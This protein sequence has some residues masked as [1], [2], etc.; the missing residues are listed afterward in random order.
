MLRYLFEYLIRWF[1]RYQLLGF[2]WLLAIVVICFEGVAGLGLPALFWCREWYGNLAIGAAV[3]CFF[4]LCSFIGFLLDHPKLSL[5]ATAAGMKT[6]FRRTFWLP[7]PLVLVRGGW[8]QWSEVACGNEWVVV[9]GYGAGVLAVRFA[10]PQLERLATPLSRKPWFPRL[11][12][13]LAGVGNQSA[14]PDLW[15]HAYAFLLTAILGVVY[16]FLAAFVTRLPVN[17]AVSICIILGLIVLFYGALRFFLPRAML[18]ALFA[19]VAWVFGVNQIPRKHRFDELRAVPPL[20]LAKYAEE[21][22]GGRITRNQDLIEDASALNAWR[23]GVSACGP[24]P[25]MVIVMTSGGGIRAAVWMAAVLEQLDRVKSPC[26]LRRHIRVITGA[27]GG[28][29]GAG[30]YVAAHATGSAIDPKLI[31]QDSLDSVAKYLALRDIPGQLAPWRYRDRGFALEQA[32]RDNAPPMGVRFDE[33]R[34][35]E[36]R[37]T[38]PSLI[39]SPAS[40]DDGRRVLV[41]NLQLKGLT[42]HRDFSASAVQFYELYPGAAITVSTAARMS[43]SFPWVSPASELPT[44]ELRR[45]GDAGY[46]DNFGGFVASAWIEKN[47]TWLATNTSGI[48][49]VQIRDSTFGADL[50]NVA[51]VPRD[52]DD[53]PRSTRVSRGFSEVIAPIQGVA[54]TRGAAMNFRSDFDLATLANQFPDGFLTSMDVEL[55]NGIAPLTWNLTERAAKDIIAAAPAATE[56]VINW[57]SRFSTAPTTAAPVQ[58]CPPV[59]SM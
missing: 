28:M 11:V 39:Y 56:D 25:K 16:A 26:E 15:M 50:R 9:A 52:E 4:A 10:A 12:T 6:Y 7:T 31:A 54:A 44:R 2:T 59:P 13:W 29:V 23:A 35:L 46:F 48:L 53:K 32:W 45:I 51:S 41:S 3:A 1:S 20:S 17:A 14:P 27:S 38:I 24:K 37:G 36:R 19:L 8:R 33:L 43:A 18:L 58:P 42:H 22:K 57:W 30:Y 49:V 34:T 47:R 21:T 40:L 5:P 55:S